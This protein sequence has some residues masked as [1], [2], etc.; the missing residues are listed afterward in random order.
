MNQDL[1]T[2]NVT[3]GTDILQ[4]TSSTERDRRLAALRESMRL[5]GLDALVV[6][7]RSNYRGR[8]F[9][10]SDIWQLVGDGFVV[11]LP[12]GAP[13]FVSHPIMGLA[14]AKRTTWVR[15][16]RKNLNLGEEVGR[17]FI[18]YGLS[19]AEIGIVGLADALSANYL[20]EL[21]EMLPKA[22]FKD[23]TALY[24][25][26]QQVKSSE[27]IVGVQETCDLIREVFEEIEPAIAPG[28]SQV[29]VFA[30]AHS[31]ARKRGL[32]EP[33][34]LVQSPPYYAGLSA[35]GGSISPDD[36]IM[37]WIESAGPSGYWSEVRRCYT[38]GRPADNLRQFWELQTE[39]WSA[40]LEAMKPE[41]PA[42]NFV[43]AVEGVLGR[44][45]YTL[46]L[47]HVAWPLHGIGSDA[48][49][50]F[51]YPGKDRLLRENEVVSVHPFPKCPDERDQARFGFLGFADNVVVTSLGAE[52]MTYKTAP[53]LVVL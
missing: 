35:N 40:G 33:M 28:V 21:R 46:D 23:A 34:V 48:T 39:A 41:A 1:L 51:W 27:E 30:A 49:E 16:F 25:E 12:E 29:D 2:E 10:V 42:S 45:G 53:D 38:F 22:K 18:D 14:Q 9:Y 44:H 52:A 4:F 47:N 20:S 50:G 3:D 36:P 24:E 32:R 15:D 8:L 26:V 31:A 7:G 6:A 37:I 11:I 5:E 13:V 19:G 17:V 43:R